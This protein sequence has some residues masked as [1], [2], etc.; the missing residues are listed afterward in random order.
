MANPTGIDQNRKRFLF[1]VYSYTA[2][3]VFPVLIIINYLEGDSLEIIIDLLVIAI[4]ATGAIALK[5]SHRD[6]LIY[7]LNLF[8]LAAI[9]TY[10]ISIGAG[11]ESA[12]YWAFSLPLLFFFFNGKWE[13]LVWKLLYVLCVGL[14]IA[15]PSLF[16][17]HD[18]G[19]NTVYRFLITLTI[20]VMLAFALESARYSAG[21]LLEEKNQTLLSEKERLERALK[22]VKTLSGLIPICSNCKKIRNDTGYWEQVETYI[23]AHSDADFSHGI[24]PDCI[25]KLYP[26][27]MIDTSM[28]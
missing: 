17:S 21:R 8:L 24:C 4:V 22:D 25:R 9:L 1:S 16:G 13:G 20:I 19:L 23:R 15:V 14:V 12:L 10:S 18:Y 6:A 7:R 5:K 3:V 28:K 11:E 27:F 2:L 26:E